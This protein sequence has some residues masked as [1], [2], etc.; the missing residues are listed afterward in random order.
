MP[1]MIVSLIRVRSLTWATVSPARWRASARVSPMTTPRLHCCA[2]PHTAPVA[3]CGGPD[4]IIAPCWPLEPPSSRRAGRI[5]T[6][7]GGSLR[8]G[9][10]G[11]AALPPGGDVTGRDGRDQVSWSPARPPEQAPDRLD[12]GVRAV[13]VDLAVP[14]SAR[15]RCS[16]C[17]T[18]SPHRTRARHLLSPVLSRWRTRS[19]AHRGAGGRA[20]GYPHGCAAAV[21]PRS[22]LREFHTRVR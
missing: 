5:R 19:A 14:A 8:P 12:D 11:P 16:P 17:E 20:R 21:N 10:R 1:L 3:E 18:T 4:P 13:H 2:A 7:V 6:R 22:R 15:S 9:A